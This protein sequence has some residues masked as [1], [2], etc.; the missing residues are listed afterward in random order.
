VR[1]D[2]GLTVIGASRPLIEATIR[3]AVLARPNVR[4]VARHQADALTGDRRRV[5][6]VTIRNLADQT[7]CELGVDLVVDASGRASRLSRWMAS[8]GCPP[9]PETVIDAHFGYATRRYRLPESPGSRNWRG[10]YALPLG[11]SVT[12]GGVIAPIENGQWIV[13]LSGVGADR[14]SAADTEFLPFARSLDTSYLAEVLADAEPLTPV[15]CSNSTVNHRRRF[16][17]VSGLPANVLAIGDAACTFNPIY[18]QGMTVAALSARLLDECLMRTVDRPDRLARLFHRELAALH[19]VP[20]LLAT[21]SDMSYPSTDGPPPTRRQRLLARYLDRVLAAGARDRRAQAAFLDVLNMV[22][23]PAALL[24][25]S[26]LLSVV[27]ARHGAA[28]G[29]A[30]G[31][32][33]ST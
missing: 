7:T 27:A 6:S 28:T 12:R 15:A 30:A 19:T 16:D 31:P 17:Q 2:S 14:P 32:P 1:F 26:V 25:P 11:P 29:L 18:G 9:I 8:L 13:T 5:E 23:H 3:D 22:R 10:C 20:W 24:T 33:P 21:T 4:L